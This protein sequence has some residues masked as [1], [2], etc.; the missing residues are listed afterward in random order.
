MGQD[1]IVIQEGEINYL[2]HSPFEKSS[3]NGRMG[4]VRRWV[5]RKLIIGNP[6]S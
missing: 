3:K 6:Q 5:V 1:V 2:D 4:E